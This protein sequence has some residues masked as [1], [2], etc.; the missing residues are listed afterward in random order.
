[1]TVE[2]ILAALQAILDEAASEGERELTEDEMNRYEQLEGKLVAAR[3]AVEIR[4]RNTAY[5]VVDPNIA[6]A[7]NVGTQ[8]RDDT[9]ERA[10]DHFMR[11]GQKNSD[12]IEVRDQTKGTTTEGGFLVPETFRNKLVE[13]IEDFGGL[14]ANVET[15]TTQ[16]GNTMP[17]P[18][19]DDTANLA[20][21]VAEASAPATGTGDD[22]VFGEKELGAYRYVAPGA[23][24]FTAFEPSADGLRVSVELLQDSAFDIQALVQRK[25][26]ERI[27]RAQSRHW[28]AGTGSG[29]PQGINQAAGPSDT[30][31]AAAPTYDDLIDA[32]H[33]VDPFYRRSA[34]WAF[35]DATL[36]LIEKIKDSNN[37]PVWRPLGALIGDKP[38]DGMLMGYPV[39]I[40]QG[41]P[42][43]TDGSGNE[44]G[45]FGDLREAYVIRRVRDVQMIV[46]P[47]TRARFGQVQYWVWA[48][49]DGLVQND[50]A[51]SVLKN[52]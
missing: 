48:R 44:F 51:V 17:F 5:H 37:D 38:S 13:C 30:W 43:Y 21:I 16:G 22:L 25:L 47:Y 36:A 10:F 2:E 31:T 39:V 23:D 14:A 29:Q 32:I 8:R 27:A 45:V 4:K 9:Y 1:M 49:A 20:T 19:I 6:P 15:I 41:F 34:K 24:N 40:D 46:D 33:S 3:R 52:D 35:N 12:L 42:D 50:C 18:T 26:G 7:V 11:T 28:A